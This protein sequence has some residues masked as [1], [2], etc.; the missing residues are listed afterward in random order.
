MSSANSKHFALFWMP[1]Q[2]INTCIWP[3]IDCKACG[4]R[5]FTACMS[6]R[7]QKRTST[8]TE[9]HFSRMVSKVEVFEGESSVGGLWT[10]QMEAA[11]AWASPRAHAAPIPWWFW[12]I[13][14]LGE[15]RE[16]CYREL[17]LWWEYFDLRERKDWAQE[18]MVLD[19]WCIWMSS[20]LLSQLLSMD[21][22]RTVIRRKQY[23]I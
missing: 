1:A 14:A 11:P 18:S 21:I 12:V 23:N 22:R 16:V 2:L 3:P 20:A 10:R 8:W 15:V 19:P 6:P 17:H 4:N 7:S 5:F 13:Y 9:G